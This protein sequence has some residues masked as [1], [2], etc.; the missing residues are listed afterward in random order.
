VVLAHKLGLQVIAEGVE[1]TEQ[2]DF[3]RAIGCDFAQG[4]L[5]SQ[6][7]APGQFEVLVW[8]SFGEQAGAGR[9]LTEWPM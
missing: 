9:L 8:P 2:R 4:F 5:Y 1:T 3:L 7:V 6:P